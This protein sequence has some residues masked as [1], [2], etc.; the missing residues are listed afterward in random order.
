[1]VA[2]TSLRYA[3]TA[4]GYVF[5]LAGDSQS[6]LLL[7]NESGEI[8]TVDVDKQTFKTSFQSIS[9]LLGVI[10]LNS[11]YYIILAA[12]A[13]NVGTIYNDKTIYKID[14][15]II[16]PLNKKL[17]PDEDEV[18]YLNILQNHLNTATL[19]FSYTYDLT[20]SFG[21][22]NYENSLSFNNEFMWNF[23]I[24][25]NLVELSNSNLIISNFI[26]PVIYGYCKFTKTT[27][28][29]KPI[30][31]GLIT[32]RS[33]FRAGTRYFRRGIDKNGN[34]ANFNETE[35]FLINHSNNGDKIS[36][37]LQ[38]RGSVP[39]YWGEMN[40]LKYKPNLLI[41]DGNDILPTRLHFDKSI[42]NYGCNYLV[43]L[44]NQSGYEKPIK[45]AYEN[46][47]S[48]LGDENIKYTY[49]DFH[50]EC[51]KMRWDRVKLLLNHLI[52]MGLSQN[53]YSLFTI[54]ENFIIEKT[55]S[56]IVR[57][58]CMD[59]LDRTNVVQSMLG[60]WFLQR[61]LIDNQI[62]NGELDWEKI[63]FKFNLI[64]Q[65]IWADNADY[66]SNAYSGTGAL[67]TDYTRTGKRTKKGALNDLINSITRYLKNNYL[68]GSRQDGFDLFLGNILPYKLNNSPFKDQ[69]P[70]FHQSIPYIF[71]V[72]LLIIIGTIMFPKGS[73]WEIKNI[74][75]ISIMSLLSGFSFFFMIKNGIQ[76]VNWPSLLPLD[77]LKQREIYKDGKIEGLIY[78][79]A[80]NY[81]K[82][83]EHD[84]KQ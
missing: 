81:N 30:T 33:R 26:L 45:L 6:Q 23:F 43:N 24:S 49:F 7:I 16:L 84:K 82:F 29:Q 65:S 44:V 80:E 41:A 74:S 71:I 21:K 3:E 11:N 27:I 14:S 78:E 2:T 48:A 28:N 67:K 39:V 17:K 46:A 13:T 76:Y 9:G 15:T 51:S 42:S 35:Q 59:C 77:F 72:G 20:N 55:Q 36:T 62:I 53:D 4:E 64:F 8:K 69:R 52:E 50:H 73:I 54:N 66:V 25:S 32:R 37:Y 56:H 47:I 57:T 34:V 38:I 40:N 70:S 19:Y 22:Q 12:G 5:Q 79:K 83:N 60:R 68:D 1:M 18:K 75:F 10:R 58:N 63:D 31:F 61:Q